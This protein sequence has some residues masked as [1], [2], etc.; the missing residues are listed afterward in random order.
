M[1]IALCTDFFYPELGGVQDSVALLAKTLG[2]R[3]H[4]VMIYAPRAAARDYAVANSPN[5]ELDLGSNVKICR[6]FSVSVPS[7]TGQSRFVVPTFT[8]WREFRVFQPDVIHT[9]TFFGIGLEAMW[10]RKKLK[11]PLV[12]TNHFA[13][14]EYAVAISKRLNPKI[15]SKWALKAVV[16]YYNHCDFLS[17]PSR[18]VI[19][20]MQSWGLLIRSDVV[21]NPIDT[22]VFHPPDGEKDILKKKL[23][24]SG[25]TF[26]Y[27]G[28]FSPEKYVDVLVRALP[29]VA[30]EVPDVQF[31]L[32]GHGS[33]KAHLENIAREL[34]VSKHLRFMGTLSKPDLAVGFRKIGLAQGSHES[35]VL[36][37]AKLPRN[38]LKMRFF[39]AVACEHE[40]HIRHFPRD[41][42]EC[43]HEYINVL[44]RTEFPC[45][46]EC[47]AGKSEFFLENILFAVGR[48]EHL[49]INSVRDDVTSNPEPPRLHFFDHRARGSA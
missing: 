46:N 8:R 12:G 3:G 45:V 33:E 43:A 9:N 6:L 5:K 1:R 42:R 14:G 31:M 32:A 30:R 41:H 35:K 25:S 18:S 22:E 36:R 4:Q 39:A 7:D 20:E 27:A 19:E 37:Y 44:L 24:F 10:A 47:G 16:W 13:V 15:F 11:V 48:M 21:S 34:G 26:I 29:M 17:A 23:G 40:L 49:C 2:A 28:K 38:V